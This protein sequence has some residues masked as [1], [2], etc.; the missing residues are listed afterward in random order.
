[1]YTSQLLLLYTGEKQVKQMFS[2]AYQTAQEAAERLGLSVRTIQKQA[3]E[4]RISGAQRH[5]RSWLIPVDYAPAQSTP[6]EAAVPDGV[7]DVYQ[8]TPFRQAMPLLNSAY[9]PGQVMAFIEAM[10]DADDRAIALGEYYYFAGQAEEAAKTVEVYLDSHDPALRHSASLICTFANL[11]RGHTH[12][13]HF[14]MNRLKEQLTAGFHIE[15]PVRFH[16]MGVFTATTAAVLM[17]LPTDHIPPLEPYLKHLPGGMKLFA[18]YVLAHQAY[19]KKDF[20]RCL[21]VAEMGLALSPQ[22]YPIAAVYTH[23]AAAMALMNMKRPEDAKQ[24]MAEAWRLAQPEGL[25]QPFVEHHGLLQGLVEVY[26]RKA[27]PDV[28]PRIIELTN[29]FSAGW[30]KIHNDQTGNDVADNLTTTEFT[31]AMLYS[32]GW[33]AK[34][35][36]E[37]LEISLRTV[38]RHIAAIYEK[39]GVSN[40]DM[41]GRFMLQ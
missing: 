23:I 39:L 3:S 21:T 34:E 25:L 9:P 28:L 30:R 29:V 2:T 24:H 16:A 37:H 13:A 20:V 6:Q 8:L 19:L 31:V 36:A 33:H 22:D 40:R 38:N 14:A 17:H 35:I 32:R 18:C 26:F 15:S 1:M 12:L 10:P 4:G 5:G 27:A 7:P 41:L 11:G